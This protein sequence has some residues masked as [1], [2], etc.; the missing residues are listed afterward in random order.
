MAAR[1]RWRALDH[2]DSCRDDDATVRQEDTQVNVTRQRSEEWIIVR[3]SE[4][5]TVSTTDTQIAAGI[6]ANLQAAIAAVI[7]ISVGNADQGR[8]VAQ[9][10]TQF[11][12]TRQ[13]NKQ[14]TFIDR[15]RGVSVRT[16]DTDLSVNI[17]VLLQIL[18]AIIVKLDVL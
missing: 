17:Q 9:D 11:I 6:Q 15:S 10:V 4:D 13:A 8:A 7:S 2:C 18:L 3:D 16:T 12:R 14:K 5:I 1:R